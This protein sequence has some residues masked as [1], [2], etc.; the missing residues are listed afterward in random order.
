MISHFLPSDN[1]FSYLHVLTSFV[2]TSSIDTDVLVF[3]GFKDQNLGFLGQKNCSPPKMYT[4]FRS[5]KT[6]LSYFLG[7]DPKEY[8]RKLT[9]FGVDRH[10]IDNARAA[11]PLNSLANLA[12]AVFHHTN[13]CLGQYF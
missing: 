13:K 7:F 2:I 8:R 11:M 9:A 6:C 5:E 10:E 1:D 12:Q 3:K 4:H